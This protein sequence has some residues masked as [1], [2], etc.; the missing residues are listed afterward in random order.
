[1]TY[2]AFGSYGHPDHLQAQR[3][4]NVAFE[5]AG[6]PRLY[7]DLGLAPW[8]PS[9]LYY[10]ASPRNVMVKAMNTARAAGIPGPWDNP[11]MNIENFG[12]PDELITARID[13]HPYMENKMQAIRAHKT[14]IA[15]DNFV[16]MLPAE[17]RENFLG[18]EHFVLAR[19]AP[20]QR[21]GALEEHLFAD[22]L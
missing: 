21:T 11:A 2:D 16:F 15:P 20:A 19:R 6:E 7:P 13:V 5:A 18:Y 4:T 14:Q 12:T 17:Y 8:Q 10:L 9:K 22:I 3:V 1:L